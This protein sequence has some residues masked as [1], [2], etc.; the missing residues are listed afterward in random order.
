MLNSI[1]NIVILKKK[2]SK[3]SRKTK[4]KAKKAK[5]KTN[6]Q[7]CKKIRSKC[8]IHKKPRCCKTLRCLYPNEKGRGTCVPFAF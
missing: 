7:K 2:N 1:R 8:Y 6:K 4:A 3:R 5:T